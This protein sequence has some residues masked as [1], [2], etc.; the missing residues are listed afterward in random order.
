MAIIDI[1]I[2][3]NGATGRIGSTQHIANA[4]TP[5]RAEGGL[6]AGNDR[7]MPRLLLTGRDS[8]RLSGIAKT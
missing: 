8:Q 6:P 1:G 3:I 2:I 7:I 5:I 4:L